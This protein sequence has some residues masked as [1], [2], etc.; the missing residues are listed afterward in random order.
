MYY[1][2]GESEKRQRTNSLHK[3][4]GG[5]GEAKSVAK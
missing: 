5:V 1:R 2:R 4:G 3:E